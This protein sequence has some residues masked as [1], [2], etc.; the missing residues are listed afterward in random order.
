MLEI[1]GFMDIFSSLHTAKKIVGDTRFLNIFSSL[2]TAKKIVGDTTVL[3][4]IFLATH[5]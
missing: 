4:Q 1:H 2:H 3:E 5:G